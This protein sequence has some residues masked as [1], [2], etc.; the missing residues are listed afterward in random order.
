MLL[1]SLYGG[2]VNYFVMSLRYYFCQNVSRYR[3]WSGHNYV[4]LSLYNSFFYYSSQQSNGSNDVIGDLFCRQSTNGHRPLGLNLKKTTSVLNSM[5]KKL[6]PASKV[7]RK[8]STSAI[9]T[10]T[11]V[12]QGMK[13]SKK[14]RASHFQASILRIGDWEV[15]VISTRVLFV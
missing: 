2:E 12:I 15:N 7:K 10:R 6:V 5:Q 4:I 11:T 3:K 13:P 8:E 9:H 14:L 1:T